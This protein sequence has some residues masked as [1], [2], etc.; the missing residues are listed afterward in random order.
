MKF[1]Y[2]QIYKAP[3]FQEGDFVLAD[4]EHHKAMS[5]ELITKMDAIIGVSSKIDSWDKWLPTEYGLY[6][7]PRAFS[8]FYTEYRFSIVRDAWGKEDNSL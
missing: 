1:L 7:I 6:Q 2:I 4:E 5:D 8:L 3:L